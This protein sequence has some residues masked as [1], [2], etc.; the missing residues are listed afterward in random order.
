MNRPLSLCAALLLLLAGAAPLGAQVI[1]D[2]VLLVGSSGSPEE[3]TDSD[4]RYACAAPP[5]YLSRATV[6]SPPALWT[7]RAAILAMRSR[8]PDFFPTALPTDPPVR[9]TIGPMFE[10]A[11]ACTSLLAT[12]VG[13]APF[14]CTDP[15]CGPSP[16]AGAS[17]T[18]G[19]G[20]NTHVAARSYDQRRLAVIG[21]DEERRLSNTTL[22]AADIQR[23]E[24]NGE[25]LSRFESVA[26][27]LDMATNPAHY[28]NGAVQTLQEPAGLVESFRPPGLTT[29]LPSVGGRVAD[30]QTLACRFGQLNTHGGPAGEA[31]C[32]TP[33]ACVTTAT[34]PNDP[35][36]GLAHC[37]PA[38]PLAAVPTRQPP[39]CFEPAPDIRGPLVEVIRPDD[40]DHPVL[41]YQMGG[42]CSL[43]PTVHTDRAACELAGGQW[44]DTTTPT[45]AAAVKDQYDLQPRAQ[46]FALGTDG[47]P[48]AF[49]GPPPSAW[50][51]S[52]RVCIP[53]KNYPAACTDPFRADQ[54]TCEAAEETWFERG[55]IEV[56]P[57]HGG[58]KL[59]WMQGGARVDVTAADTVTLADMA[60]VDLAVRSDCAFSPNQYIDEVGNIT[61]AAI[62]GQTGEPVATTAH[63]TTYAPGD[64]QA[65]CE[66]AGKRWVP[67][68]AALALHHACAPE[69]VPVLYPQPGCTSPPLGPVQNLQAP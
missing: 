39:P 61:T 48:D 11:I 14:A 51:D 25:W 26:W 63:C 67:A 60:D 1:V 20:G 5:S 36:R 4:A 58:H 66:A 33:S 8:S 55:C 15:A 52:I 32:V 13:T 65:A 43:N 18:T 41:A 47:H 62:R 21:S 35:C 6:N 53:G 22:T 28:T 46:D 10:N 24:D 59:T 29:A 23:L 54:A 50:P 16:T 68:G 12:S 17:C 31:L 57:V 19:A 37:N 69:I 27:G 40:R 45:F 2:P 49:Q 56:L 38:V 9:S 30:Y 3:W 34:V 64:D 44:G 7:N 42:P